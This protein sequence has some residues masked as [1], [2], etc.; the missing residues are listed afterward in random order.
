MILNSV[1]RN[2]RSDIAEKI[3]ISV[4]GFLFD[5]TPIKT[6]GTIIE[7]PVK[8]ILASSTSSSPIKIEVRSTIIAN[9][10]SAIFVSL[11]FA[12]SSAPSSSDLNSDPSA[13]ICAFDVDNTAANRPTMASAAITLG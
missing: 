11:K 6:I 2:T 12:F 9:T 3:M 4:P 13:N 7:V 8:L 10:K 1:R 5:I